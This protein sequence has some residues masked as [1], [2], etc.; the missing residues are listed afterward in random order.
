[1][2]VGPVGRIKDWFKFRETVR[3]EIGFLIERH[4]QHAAKAALE[5]LKTGRVSSRR[6][7][8]LQAAA[9]QLQP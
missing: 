7:K 8:V 3:E 6:A 2:A 5:E 9:R 4:G 1:M